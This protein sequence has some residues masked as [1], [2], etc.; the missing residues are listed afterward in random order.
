MQRWMQMSI[1][2]RLSSIFI[3]KDW[4]KDTY[5]ERLRCNLIP[6][7]PPILK[8]N[9]PDYPKLKWLKHYKRGWTIEAFELR[10]K[11]KEEGYNRNRPVILGMFNQILDGHHR[12]ICAIELGYKKIPTIKKKYVIAGFILSYVISIYEKIIKGS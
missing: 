3:K 6:T 10:E 9:K 12:T 7:Y 4:I 11:I 5:I 8:N 1:N 2:T